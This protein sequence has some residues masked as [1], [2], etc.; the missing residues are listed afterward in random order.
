[1]PPFEQ[2]R[3]SIRILFADMDRAT[4]RRLAVANLLALASGALAGLAP[5]AL[6]QMIDAAGG[7]LDAQVSPMSVALLGAVYLLCLTLGRLMTEL[8]P[9]LISAAEQQLYAGLRRR[10]FAHLLDLPLSFHLKQRTGTPIQNLQQAISGYQV[11]LFGL[12]NGTVPV[13]IEGVTVAVVLISLGQSALTAVLAMTALAYFAAMSGR[14]ANLS[15]AA[16]EVSDA[17]IQAHSLMADSLMNYEPIKCFGAERAT[18]QLFEQA[19]SR[20]EACWSRLQRRR[21]TVGL[22][23][24]AIFAVSTALSLVIATQALAQ[25]MLSLGGFVLAAMYMVQVLRPL[26]MLSSTMRDLFQSLAFIQPLMDVLHETPEDLQ[27]HDATTD[28]APMTAHAAGAPQQRRVPSLSFREIELA[29]VAGVPV[30]RK[31]SLDVPAGQSIAIVGASGCGKSSLVRLLLRLCEPQSGTVMLN[32]CPINSI[33][34]VTLRSMVAVVPQDVV[35]FNT[36]ISANIAIGKHD[37][38]AAEIERAA[39]VAGV[40]DFV[41]AL[42]SRYETRIGERGLTLSGGERQRI[43]IARAVLRDPL[44]YV[45]DEASSMLDGPNE[46]AILRKLREISAG[47]TTITIAHRLSTIQHADTIAV[48]D[49][50]QV[51]ELG[52]HVQLL[53]RDGLYAG[54]WHLQQASKSVGAN[55]LSP[56]GLCA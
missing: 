37:A 35:L 52:N 36:T 19:S 23:V 4:A 39:R 54:M 28:V 33:P 25:G 9:L 51:A 38:T 17:S 48:I 42:P 11:I 14:T 1:M 46:D 6:K 21:L 12:V 47:R 10:Y 55:S 26:E 44:V 56:A 31:L 2:V 32:D 41:A 16:R 30:L 27:K 43:A 49:E 53:A 13:L 18:V 7:I 20:L 40:H 29:F 24:T 34:L 8:R 3:T 22:T 5:L 50:G 15:A 45:F